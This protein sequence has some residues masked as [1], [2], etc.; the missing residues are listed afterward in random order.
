MIDLN[1]AEPRSADLAP[2]AVTAGEAGCVPPAEDTTLGLVELLLKAPARVDELN[3]DIGRQADLLPRFLFIALAAYLVF[4]FVLVLV[5]QVAPLPAP[6]Y[7][8][9]RVPPARWSDGTALSLPLAYSISI[10]LAACVCL[11][12]FYFF[13]LLAGAKLTGLQIVSLLGKGMAANGIL[14]LGILPIYMAIA[15]GMIVL[16]SPPTA[17]QAVLLLGLLLPFVSGLWG[18]HAVYQGL[19]RLVEPLPAEW[20]CHRRCFLRRLILSW[21]AVYAAVLPI[22]I[23]RLWEF[24][25]ALVQFG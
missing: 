21:S 12:T 6:D 23:Y 8:W 14:L 22:M 9:W 13:S 7:A 10:V 1:V 19:L 25:A 24:F 3:R 18:L 16:H 17:L 4:S 2:E 20:Q 15:L 5:L 11:P